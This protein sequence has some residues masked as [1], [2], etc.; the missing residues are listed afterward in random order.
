[1]IDVPVVFSREIVEGP[2]SAIRRL[3]QGLGNGLFPSQAEPNAARFIGA[4][5]CP[6]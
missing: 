5:E 2:K 1:M 3:A 6:Q 4:M